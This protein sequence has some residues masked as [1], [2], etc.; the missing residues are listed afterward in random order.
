MC[1]MYLTN[2]SKIHTEF[3]KKLC[4]NLK[5][6][7]IMK[8][9]TISGLDGSGK[10]TQL[11]LIEKKLSKNYKTERLHMIDFSIANKILKKQEKEK[12]L[13]KSKAK[14]SAGFGGVF[15]RKIALIVDVFRFRIHY[16]IKTFEN[17]INFLI[18]DRYFYDQIINIKYLDK[19]TNPDRKPFWQ[20]IVENQM[21]VPDLKIYLQIE[22]KIIL[23][24]NPKL[25]QGRVYLIKKYFLFEVLSRRWH[26]SK[27]NGRINKEKIYQT[28]ISLI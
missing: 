23:K 21:I 28:I 24:R 27:V 26:L 12:N 14:T 5:F 20:I 8:L 9:I 6:R 11:D 3:N 25:E 7:E 13:V 15:L 2:T 19:H 17:K 10:T 16:R 18:I 1:K 22:P 4:Q